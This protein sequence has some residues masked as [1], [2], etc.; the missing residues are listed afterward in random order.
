MCANGVVKAFVSMALL[1]CLSWTSPIRAADNESGGSTNV[2]VYCCYETDY[3]CIFITNPGTWLVPK[4]TLI[5]LNYIA[6]LT[7]CSDV[8]WSAHFDNNNP[9]VVTKSHLGTK[10]VLPDNYETVNWIAFY[11]AI[12]KGEATIT[13]TIGDYQYEYV[14][15]VY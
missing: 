9:E 10:H 2:F 13:L 12:K 4:G 15:I 6:N 7:G 5:E 8:V 1:I 11:K 14:F 3:E